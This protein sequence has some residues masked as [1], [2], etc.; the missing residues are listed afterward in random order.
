MNRDHC[1]PITPPKASR[2]NRDHCQP[3]TPDQVL[4]ANRV[5]QIQAAVQSLNEALAPRSFSADFR[6]IA[7]SWRLDS[8]DGTNSWPA[9]TP[10]FHF[11]YFLVTTFENPRIIF[12]KIRKSTDA[13][14]SFLDR[15]KD[16]ETDGF[17]RQARN[18]IREML[19]T[20][21]PTVPPPDLLHHH[22]LS[23][24]AAVDV[25]NLIPGPL[26]AFHESL[27][28]EFDLDRSARGYLVTVR[29]IDPEGK[30]PDI[31]SLL[32]FEPIL[33]SL[34]D[35]RT[36]PRIETYAKANGYGVKQR[37]VACFNG[38]RANSNVNIAAV[39]WDLSNWLRGRDRQRKR[40]PS[41]FQMLWIPVYEASQSGQFA[42]RFLGWLFKFLDKRLKSDNAVLRK[43][44]SD[45]IST[46]NCFS[47]ELIE[48]DN[49]SFLTLA[50][51]E[52][53]K[54]NPEHFLARHLSSR[55]GWKN[56]QAQRPWTHSDNDIREQCNEWWRVVNEEFQVRLDPTLFEDPEG[57]G[58]FT[59]LGYL[60]LQ[61]G[62]NV[63]PKRLT[64]WNSKDCL[65]QAKHIRDL[66]RRVSCAMRH[67]RNAQDAKA[68]Q[69][70]ASWAHEV[71]NYT[72]PTIGTLRALSKERL[73]K[74][75]RE[76]A[77]ERVLN[78]VCI[79]NAEATAYSHRLR[80]RPH[81]L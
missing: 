55:E 52:Q 58:N 76:D 61:C 78:A 12:D 71:K 70:A 20:N 72:G 6:F 30:E 8:L 14:N 75:P 37:D 63:V 81:E 42:G 15:F 69:Q 25:D 21:R 44:V 49:R 79:L 32:D 73:G 56:V 68:R 24:F 64:K 1:Q 19:E 9:S 80:R 74:K 51:N 43:D 41:E 5:Y 47:Q 40:L 35:T 39:Y 48:I 33:L 54:K 67:I 62:S 18:F 3:I 17:V 2:M 45:C 28:D 31:K 13:W 53:D 38:E 26:Q 77:I 34:N 57:W 46:C 10:T 4:S 65:R 11:T 16:D 29:P 66:A 60:S 59:D 7:R 22:L 36:I 50:F 27:S 23:L